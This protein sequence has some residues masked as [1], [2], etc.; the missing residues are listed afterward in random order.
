MRSRKRY[1]PKSAQIYF[2]NSLDPKF[3]FRNHK[4]NTLSVIEL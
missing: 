4:K 2:F 3:L 1:Q